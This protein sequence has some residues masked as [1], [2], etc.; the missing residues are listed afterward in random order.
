ML[1]PVFQS[2]TVR[3]R[4]VQAQLVNAVA[5]QP[6]FTPDGH[7][8]RVVV[9]TPYCDA[10]VRNGRDYIGVAL[11]ITLAARVDRGAV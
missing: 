6:R 10:R 5:R 2:R 4:E 7:G 1:R 3:G 11:A 8:R 9:I